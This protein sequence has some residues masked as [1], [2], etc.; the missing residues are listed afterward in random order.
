MKSTLQQTIKE[1]KK[2][3]AQYDIVKVG[4][5]IKFVRRK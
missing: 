3:S 5:R 1:L 2:L 4:K